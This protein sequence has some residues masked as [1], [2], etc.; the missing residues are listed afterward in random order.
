MSGYGGERGFLL[1]VIGGR[2]GGKA[3]A[4][5]M[6]NPSLP[7]DDVESG[8]YWFTAARKGEVAGGENC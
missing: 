4:K 5:K 3:G 1:L 2:Q 8:G 6:E 7:W